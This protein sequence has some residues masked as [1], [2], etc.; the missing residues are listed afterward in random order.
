MFSAIAI[1]AAILG[2][3]AFPASAS[4]ASHP[5]VH[6]FTMPSVTGIKAWGTYTFAKGKVSIKLCVREITSNVDYALVVGTATN[7]NVT[8]HQSIDAQVIGTGKQVCKS[9]TTKDKAHLYVTAS[10]GTTDGKSHVGKVR[11]IY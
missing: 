11:K 1:G 2:L 7:A 5:K 3:T 4:A 6:S 10:S 9:L 8:K